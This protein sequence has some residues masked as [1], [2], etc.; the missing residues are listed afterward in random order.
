MRND[1]ARDVGKRTSAPAPV[2]LQRVLAI[3][4]VIVCFE[5]GV[6]LILLPWKDLWTKNSM[7]A[8]YPTLHLWM[9]TPFIRGIV[10]GLGLLD[11]WI[12]VS[13]AITYRDRR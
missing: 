12:G 7:L 2:W 10:S 11:L 5:L 4:F 1:E 6:M 8:S 13:A 3:V 9:N